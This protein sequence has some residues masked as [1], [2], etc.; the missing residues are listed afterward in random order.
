MHIVIDLQGA[1]SGSHARGIGR[2][3]LSLSKA[4]INNRGAHDITIL[5]NADFK[6]TLQTVR[7]IFVPLL[8][9]D[10]IRL[11]YPATPAYYADPAN[12]FRSRVS[13]QIK[14]ATI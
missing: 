5:L 14:M 10:R 6:E 13:N 7:D 12:N 11:W 3:S 9:P 8:P 4:I 1:Q 2:Y